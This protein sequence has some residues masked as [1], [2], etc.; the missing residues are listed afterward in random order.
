M[1]YLQKKRLGEAATLLSDSVLSITEIGY[2]CGFESPSYF[3][4]QFGKA[5]G[6]SPRQYRRSI[7]DSHM[8]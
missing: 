4:N 8:K 5:M 3:T 6:M 7:H 1:E 2:R